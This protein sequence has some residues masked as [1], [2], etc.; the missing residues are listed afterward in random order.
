MSLMSLMIVF[1]IAFDECHAF[2]AFDVCDVFDA[3]GDCFH[4][5][6]DVIDAF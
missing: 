1:M 3:F 4:D 6:C 5:E 2:D